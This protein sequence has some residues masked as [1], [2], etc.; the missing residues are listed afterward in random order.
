[1]RAAAWVGTIV[2]ACAACHVYD[3]VDEIPHDEYADTATAM[4]AILAGAYGTRVYAVGEY[5]PTRDMVAKSPLARF[6]GE[7]IGLLEPYARHLVVEAWLDGACN[8]SST[9]RA[10]DSLAAQVQ[11]ATGR[12]SAQRRDVAGLVARTGALNIQAHGLPMTCIEQS[13]MLDGR[14]RVDFWRLL[15]LVTEKL[16]DTALALVED[17]RTE[18]A[19]IVYGGALHN[20]LY[21]RWPL[22]DISYAHTLRK[23]LGGDGVLEID[24]VVPEIVAHMNGIWHEPWFPLLGRAAPG[25]V[26]VWERG[27]DSYVII[28]PAQSEAVAKVARP[29]GLM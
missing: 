19:V 7:I 3:P 29:A 4:R 10:A 16:H 17:A 23:E 22:E 14:G 15:V 9:D 25:R 18:R 2:L 26:I 13:A 28:L 12:P 11:A 20:D 1:M 6:T 8:A 5:H 21:P 24:L 27:I